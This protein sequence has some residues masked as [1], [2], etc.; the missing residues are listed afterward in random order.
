VIEELRYDSHGGGQHTLSDDDVRSMNEFLKKVLLPVLRSDWNPRSESLPPSSLE[1]QLLHYFPDFGNHL[2]N[3]PVVTAVGREMLR[4]ERAR[5][6]MHR[7]LRR[8]RYYR[9][10]ELKRLKTRKKEPS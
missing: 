6:R 4:M 3:R 2:L 7:S 5:F 9:A 10:A 1:A 8:F